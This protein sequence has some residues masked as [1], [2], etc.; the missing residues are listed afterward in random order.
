MSLSRTLQFFTRHSYR[1][2]KR[3]KCHFCLAFCS[4]F[5]VVIFSLVVNTLVQRGP[6]IFLK[7]V[8]GTEGE[9]DGVIRGAYGDHESAKYSTMN[10]DNMLNYTRIYETY[11]DKYRLSPR[12]TFCGSKIGTD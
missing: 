8:E 12:K 4:V 2:I 9:I 7:V 11:G 10:E 6:I 1:D 5:I 3:K